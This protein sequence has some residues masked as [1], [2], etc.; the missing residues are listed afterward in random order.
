MINEV[1][2]KEWYCN[3]AKENGYELTN[4]SDRIIATLHRTNG[5]CPC[6]YAMWKKTRPEELDKII[7]P[8][9]EHKEEIER[10]GYCHCHLFKKKEKT[11]E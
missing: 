4:A 11:N 10:D 2:P 7:C 3:Y 1:H 6:K 9:A 8:C 5:Y